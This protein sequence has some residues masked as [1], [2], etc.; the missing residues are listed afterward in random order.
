MRLAL[1]EADRRQRKL[2]L[3]F[4]K[5][6]IRPHFV[7]NALNAI[8]SVSRTDAVKARK[9]LVEFSRYLH[10]CYSVKDLDDK[11]PIGNELSFV[12]AYVALEQARYPDSLYVAYEIDDVFLM[13]PPLTLQPLV[14]NAIIHGIREKPG[15]GHIRIYV[16]DRGEFTQIGVLDDGVGISKEAAATLL[17][18]NYQGTGV[19][20]CNINRRM[21]RLYNT[22]LHLDSR[23]DGGTDAYILVPKE[24]EVCCE[25]Y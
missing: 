18:S 15:D 2:E 16:K 24:G 23:P 14:E 21:Q 10:N 19:G 12:R 6:Q 17:S 11:V 7:N 8:I 1:D 5:S 20:I 25:P 22:G 13:V 3:Q 4:L 9:L